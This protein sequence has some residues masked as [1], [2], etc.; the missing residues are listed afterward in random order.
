MEKL[1]WKGKSLLAPVPVVMVSC[2]SMEKPNII[3]IAW[4]GT[5]CSQPSMT[6]ISIRPE[7]YSYDIVK[8]SKEFVINLVSENISKAADFCGV[9]SGKDIDKF[10]ACS[11][12][13]KKASEIECPL[14]LQSPINLECR[15]KDIIHLGGHDMF[16]SEILAVNVA[17]SLVDKNGKLE[18]DKAR[19]V[20]FAH[21]EYFSLGK[22]MGTLGTPSAKKQK[23]YTEK[24]HRTA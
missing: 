15:V 2:G 16:L 8:N 14:I 9:R 22:S 4:T 5:V 24:F 6:Y 3:T 1:V 18:I 12:T 23:R 10:E 21:G 7:R 20:A 19:L 17:E 11:L 13:P